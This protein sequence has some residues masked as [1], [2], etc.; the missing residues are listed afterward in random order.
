MAL[1]PPTNVKYYQK[2]SDNF[3]TNFKIINLIINYFKKMEFFKA[4]TLQVIDLFVLNL[5]VSEKSIKC[6]SSIVNDPQELI[7]N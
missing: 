3:H 2:S 7:I 1:L 4:L 6:R 5:E